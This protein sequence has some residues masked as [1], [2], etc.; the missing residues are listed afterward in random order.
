MATQK[1][2][3][4]DQVDWDE[5]SRSNG[6][7][8]SV[9]T[10]GMLATSLPLLGLAAYDWQFV[11]RREATFAFLGLAFDVPGIDYV[12]AFTLL[13]F[14]FYV[15]LPLHQ[16]PRMTAYYWQEFKRNRPAVVS[17]VWLGFV[18]AGGLVGPLFVNVPQQDVLAG[19]QPP[20]FL[21]VDEANTAQCLGDIVNGRCQGTWEYPL[22]TTRGGKGVF[23]S[24]VHGMTISMKIG[25]IATTLAVTMGVLFGTVSAYAGGWVDEV[26]MRYVDIQQSWPTL[27]MYLL[28]LYVF[29]GGLVVFILLFGLFSWEGMARYVRSKALSVAEEEYIQAV[30]MSGASTYRVVRRHVVPNTA[31]SIITDITLLVPAFLLAEAQ[32]AFLG[33][34][35]SGVPSWG[36]L[37][38]A[39]RSD[40]A[41][42]P[43]IVLAPGL[44]LFLTILAFNF[45]GDALL[46]A[47]N[48]EAEA[49]AER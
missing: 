25:F 48:P 29:G 35:D 7:S 3:R 4:F 31:S 46:D 36:Q 8:L 21:T 49:E 40:L 16:N 12:F 38:S 23:V 14:A 43:W 45:L 22:G 15:L 1:P 26:L 10:K 17:L 34:G 32:L 13:L 11:G 37:I 28:V 27:I 44:M 18:F 33:L 5:V 9:N 19:H 24:I 6:V 41:F 47:L 30:R 20:V 2:E 39:G 42:A